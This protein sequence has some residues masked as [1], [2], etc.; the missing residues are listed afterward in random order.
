VRNASLAGSAVAPSLSL[1]ETSSFGSAPW[2]PPP[3]TVAVVAQI[4][5]V[6]SRPTV[7]VRFRRPPVAGAHGR[8]VVALIPAG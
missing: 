2:P 1:T 3:L 4:V 5:T 6:P 8:P 7:P